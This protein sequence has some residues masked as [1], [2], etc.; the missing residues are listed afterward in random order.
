MYIYNY[1]FMYIIKVKREIAS[2]N[3]FRFIISFSEGE[4]NTNTIE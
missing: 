3:K 2:D 1:N 4:F